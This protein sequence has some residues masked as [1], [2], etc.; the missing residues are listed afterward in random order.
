ETSSS[1]SPVD[2]HIHELLF[3]YVA[4]VV[5]GFLLT[6]IPNWTGRLPV[7]GLPLLGLVLLWSA[8]RFIVFFSAQ[9]GWL[10][11]AVIDCAFL[12]AVVAAAATEI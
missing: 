4:A 6:A 7:Q 10:L 5:T 12:L 3:G 11:S 2:W 1:F 9:A 8:G